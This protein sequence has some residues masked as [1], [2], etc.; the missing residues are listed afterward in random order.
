MDDPVVK[1][2]PAG[3]DNIAGMNK[4][5]D[6]IVDAVRAAQA[7][8][9]D[10]VAV[11]YVIGAFVGH[12][13]SCGSSSLENTNAALGY[14]QQVMIETALENLNKPDPKEIN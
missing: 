1:P 7:E 13:A 5:S 10:A 9:V 14:V 8:G 11:Y 4:L 3:F 2:A 6:A 12:I